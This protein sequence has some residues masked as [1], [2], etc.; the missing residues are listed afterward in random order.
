V[1]ERQVPLVRTVVPAKLY[2][3][4]MMRAWRAD[5][6]QLPTQPQVGVLWAQYMVE[7]G[8]SAC[9][10]WNI[11]N[12]KHVNGDGYDWF[13]LPGTWEI[14]NGKRVVLP[15]GHPGR[16]FRAFPSLDVAMVDHL[17]FLKRRFSSCWP[18]VIA[19][20]S[21]G[22]VH[23]LKAGRDGVEGT[24]DDY[25]TAPVKAY[26]DLH[27]HY[28]KQWT[29]MSAFEEAEKEYLAILEKETEPAPP[30]GPVTIEGG[31]IHPRVPLGLPGECFEPGDPDDPEGGAA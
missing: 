27:G 31:I 18:K 29:R 1:S 4:A 21:P 13:D 3:G 17:A 14:V 7:T 12:V 6:H 26:V 30:D 19:G 16:R 20:D 15:E 25:F 2:A 5:Y 11:G 24:G 8:G 22:F 23:A 28:F 9:W 10:C